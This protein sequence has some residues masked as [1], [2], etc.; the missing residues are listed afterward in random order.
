MEMF[1]ASS[2]SLFALLCRQRHKE[3]VL[4]DDLANFFKHTCGWV[5]A[6]SA[7]SPGIFFNMIGAINLSTAQRL[8]KQLQ[9]RTALND[10][11]DKVK[12]TFPLAAQAEIDYALECLCRHLKRGPEKQLNDAKKVPV[13][14]AQQ[15]ADVAQQNQDVHHGQDDDGTGYKVRDGRTVQLNANIPDGENVLLQSG[16]LSD[17]WKQLKAFL[18]NKN[19]AHRAQLQTDPGEAVLYRWYDGKVI[20]AVE[21]GANKGKFCIKYPWRNATEY[22]ILNKSKYTTDW[23]VLVDAN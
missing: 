5:E 8:A 13:A 21:R 18:M 9:R 7:S 11:V 23:V 15:V 17:E 4:G 10:Q 16:H 6:Q 12:A 14:L 20:G 2:R 22:V 3:V 1:P 19:I